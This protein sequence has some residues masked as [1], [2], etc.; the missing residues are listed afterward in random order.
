MSPIEVLLLFVPTGST[1][2]QEGDHVLI[3]TEQDQV[4]EQVRQKLL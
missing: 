2:L 1:V 3:T 4:A